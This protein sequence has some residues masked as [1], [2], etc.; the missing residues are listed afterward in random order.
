MSDAELEQDDDVRQVLA[1][2]ESRWAVAMVESVRRELPCG[3]IRRVM[4]R[5]VG[6]TLV[7]IVIH[8][9]DC[10]EGSVCFESGSQLADEIRSIL[11]IADGVQI[12]VVDLHDDAWATG[13][14]E[15][16]DPEGSP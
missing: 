15:A 4:H 16:G 3:A 13:L 11:H 5:F 7:I 8:D 1:V 14:E 10:H 9:M 6:E 12:L 2:A